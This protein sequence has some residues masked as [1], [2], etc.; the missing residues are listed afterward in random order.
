MAATDASSISVCLCL[1]LCHCQTN[2]HMRVALQSTSKQHCTRSTLPAAE[3][4]LA[5]RLWIPALAMM[6]LLVQS[7]ALA[8]AGSSIF[9]L[10]AGCTV[11]LPLPLSPSHPVTW[12]P[13]RPVFHMSRKPAITRP[14]QSASSSP[15]HQQLQPLLVS[16]HFRCHVLRADIAR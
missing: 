8:P 6:C 14:Y 5:Q 15:L 9:R 13:H 4:A 7:A 2:L 11:R 16:T 12:R 1:C 10:H 3:E